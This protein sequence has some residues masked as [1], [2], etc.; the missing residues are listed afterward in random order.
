MNEKRL[1]YVILERAS[2]RGNEYAWPLDAVEDAI[3]A[4]AAAGLATTG[5]QAQFRLQGGTYEMH[6]INAN[7]SGRRGDESWEEYVA[8]SA[9]E[10]AGT[11]RIIVARTDFLLEAQRWPALREKVERGEPVLDHLC[12]V[13]Y[14][15]TDEK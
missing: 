7:A 14:F 1:P 10:V 9:D 6:W 2:L 3:T 11:F 15:D 8:R 12:F 13:L 4:A 5:G